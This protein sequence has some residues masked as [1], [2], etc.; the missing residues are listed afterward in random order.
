MA[1]NLL[2]VFYQFLF[3]AKQ[4]K[5][6]PSALAPSTPYPN[7]SS[8]SHFYLP[9][10]LGE[11]GLEVMFFLPTIE[12]WLANGWRIYAR[13]PELYPK[14]TAFFHDEMFGKIDD[15]M[16]RYQRRPLGQTT[17][18][19]HYLPLALGL[20]GAG[21][22]YKITSRLAT[23]EALH[24]DSDILF[25][26]ELHDIL[27]PTIL[28]EGR[29]Q[30]MW[31][32]ELMIPEEHYI[33]G[34]RYGHYFSSGPLVPS[35]KPPDY[36]QGP[37]TMPA[38]IGMQLRHYHAPDRNSHM[39]KI[40]EL[41]QEAAKFL[42][43]PVLCYGPETGTFHPPQFPQTYELAAQQGKRLLCF[44]L[45]ALKS[46]SLMFAPDSGWAD[47][48]G[49]LQIPTLVEDPVNDRN[50]LARLAIFQP[51]MRTLEDNQP[52]ADQIR[53]LYSHPKQVT[54]VQPARQPLAMNIPKGFANNYLT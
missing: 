52:I 23:K 2:S 53:Q 35:Y 13:R 3:L 46:C 20:D 42:G 14:G 33:H 15:L 21:S 40:V 37:P 8:P 9:P 41:V 19:G 30:V 1:Y 27:R 28:A 10:Y 49:W 44:E 26:K 51:T 4:G 38:H 43:L 39:V 22:T 6:S 47:L 54:I 34:D 31:D 48:M 12:P 16:R 18:A 25:Q 11:M 7:H 29:P 32:K 45:Q 50:N 17:T 5:F 36:A 24:C